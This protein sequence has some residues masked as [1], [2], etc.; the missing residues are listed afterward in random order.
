MKGSSR[1]EAKAHLVSQPEGDNPPQPRPRVLSTPRGGG[2]GT[3][4]LDS[5]ISRPPGTGHR[6]LI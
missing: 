3:G 6:V 4:T 5:E 1:F 2:P